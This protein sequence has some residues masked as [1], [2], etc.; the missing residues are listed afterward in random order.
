MTVQLR[1]RRTGATAFLVPS[2]I[3]SLF[4]LPGCD[5]DVGYLSVGGGG[6]VNSAGESGD[7]AGA[8]NSGGAAGASASG[9]DSNAVPEGGAATSGAAGAATAGAS[10]AGSAGE[11]DEPRLEI[12]TK[13]GQVVANSNDFGIDGEVRKY[14]ADPDLVTGDF[15]GT[16]MCVKGTL[17]AALGNDFNRYWGGGIQFALKKSPAGGPGTVYDATAHGVAGF[18]VVLSGAKLPPVIRLQYKDIHNLDSYCKEVNTTGGGT[19]TFL[20]S[21]AFHDCWVP[22]GMPIPATELE[23]LEFHVVPTPDKNVAIDFCVKRIT[24]IPSTAVAAAH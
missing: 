7:A 4:A 22:G 13:D 5:P 17:I 1:S 16:K 8:M 6:S 14:A 11:S 12:I 2:L 9:G 21:E 20:I 18:E 15:A 23:N 19:F 24:V 10:D 3:G